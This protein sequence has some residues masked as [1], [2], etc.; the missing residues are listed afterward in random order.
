MDDLVAFLRAR[1]D[2]DEKL[3]RDVIAEREEY[4]QGPRRHT[5]RY[6]FPARNARALH[7]GIHGPERVL[8]EVEAKRRIVEGCVESLE[9]EARRDYVTEGGDN[10]SAVLAR[11]TLRMLALPYA[12]HPEYR[13]EWK[14]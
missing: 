1:L 6:P 14:P 12:D 9:R 2:E 7:D 8:R 3:A 10:D 5:T 13:D 11:F 4:P